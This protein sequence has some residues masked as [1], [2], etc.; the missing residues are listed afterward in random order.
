MATKRQTVRIL[1][2]GTAALLLLSLSAIGLFACPYN[3]TCPMHGTNCTGTGNQKYT[4]GG[5]H[6]WA[7]FQCP[8][9]GSEAAHTFWVQCD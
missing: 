4:D 6:H 3:A 5:Q 8:G 7:E 2:F 9:R 1:L